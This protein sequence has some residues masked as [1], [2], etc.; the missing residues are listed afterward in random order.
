MK[1]AIIFGLTVVLTASCV[2][3]LDDY[4]IDKKRASAVPASTLFSNAVKDLIDNFTTPNVNVNNFRFYI[5]YWTA[6]TYTQEPRYDLTSRTIPQNFWTPFYR[7]ALSDLKESRRLIDADG[8][9]LPAV[10]ANQVAQTEI[11]SVLA[12]SSL[13][14]TFG[15]VPYSKALSTAT[16]L[17]SYDN[18]ETI[19]TDI[20]VRLDEALA[21][22]NASAAGMPASSDVMYGGNITK[23]IKFGNSLKLRLAMIIADKNPTK[24]QTMVTQVTSDLTKLISSN[25]ENAR[26]TYL[27]S[28]PNNNPISNNTIAPFTTR[29]DFVVSET[30]VNKMNGLNDPRRPFYFTSIGGNFV[31]G[32]NGFPNSYASTSHISDKITSPTFEGLFMDYAEVQ[33]L[34]AEAVERGF[35]NG[36]AGDFYREAITASITYWGGTVAEANTYLAQPSVA[37]STATGNYKQKIGEQK[38]IALY[39]RG[40]D[41]WVEWRRLDFPVL[42]PVSGS[43]VPT[44]LIIPLRLIYPV[45][46]QTQNGKSYSDASNTIGGDLTS[47]RIF[48]DM[49]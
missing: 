44:G 31:G 20:L 21:N 16:T 25:A 12:W 36:V 38:W 18:A 17:P 9:L 33:F 10:K 48:W 8:T 22:L 6:V 1:R 23:W 7:D 28:S 45:S 11:M 39:N 43:G 27:S 14:N 2:D 34:L 32:V 41:S 5:Q 42:T 46:E 19:Y 15:N 49:N 13:V 47:V 37:Y 29:Q 26:H 24:A 35:L 30:I 3:S 40:Y 4:N